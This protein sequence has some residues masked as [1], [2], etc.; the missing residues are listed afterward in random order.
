M[1]YK[2]DNIQLSQETAN[3]VNTA[4]VK[5]VKEIHLGFSNI[6]VLTA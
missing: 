5:C 4:M 2:V 6:P 1:I 3:V